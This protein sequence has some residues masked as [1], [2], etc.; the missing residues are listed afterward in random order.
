MATGALADPPPPAQGATLQSGQA[1]AEPVRRRHCE[2]STPIGSS[3]PRRSCAMYTDE[4]W[5]ARREAIREAERRNN[6]AFANC[7]RGDYATECRV[8]R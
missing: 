1:P 3:M 5:Q 8:S 4:E 2:T 7:D 6:E